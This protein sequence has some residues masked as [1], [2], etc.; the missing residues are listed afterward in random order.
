VEGRLGIVVDEAKTDGLGIVGEV[1]SAV[2]CPTRARTIGIRRRRRF[3]LCLDV[4][5][6]IDLPTLDGMEPAL[7]QVRLGF[8]V[9]PGGIE[10]ISFGH[11]GEGAEGGIGAALE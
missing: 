6:A 7:G 11:P 10:G 9:G 3:G 8:E 1:Q 2:E 5:Q 4:R